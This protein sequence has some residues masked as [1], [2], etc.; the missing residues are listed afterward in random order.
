MKTRVS[1]KFTKD[2]KIIILIAV[3]QR[4]HMLTRIRLV[5]LNLL[6]GL[7]EGLLVKAADGQ[8]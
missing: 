1:I 7:L 4:R 3:T 2:T 5:R 8:H 6:D